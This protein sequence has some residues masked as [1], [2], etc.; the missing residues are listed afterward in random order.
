M[1]DIVQM[2]SADVAAIPGDSTPATPGIQNALRRSND[3]DPVS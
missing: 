1:R 2:G 3:V